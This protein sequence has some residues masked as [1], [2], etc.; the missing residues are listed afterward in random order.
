MNRKIEVLVR[1]VVNKLQQEHPDLFKSDEPEIHH[2]VKITERNFKKRIADLEV[3]REGLGL[4]VTKLC[5]LSGVSRRTYYRFIKAYG[6]RSQYNYN[7]FIQTLNDLTLVDKVD[8]DLDKIKNSY[9]QG[10]TL[11]TDLPPR[12]S[13]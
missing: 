11:L 13:K 3:R 12:L 5:L 6:K 7:R 4:D 1:L 8:L 9:Q 10:E 2:A